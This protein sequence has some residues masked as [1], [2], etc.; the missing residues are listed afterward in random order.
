MA[1]NEID[2]ILEM[3]PSANKEDLLILA[4]WGNRLL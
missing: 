1:M 4:M 3:N 2:I